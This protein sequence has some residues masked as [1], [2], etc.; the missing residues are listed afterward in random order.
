VLDYS[1]EPGT[2]RPGTPA[3]LRL[4]RRAL[5][6]MDIPYRVFA[7]LLGARAQQV[8]A[9]RHGE[10]RA[11]AAPTT[12]GPPG[13]VLADEY[14]IDVPAGTPAG[15]YLIELG[16]YDP[17]ISERLALPNGET[18]LILGTPLQVS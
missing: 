17:R 6:E 9:Q 12:G 16:F 10:P 13:E 1:L 8:L 14:R 18:R 2:V 11:G 5:S 7:H 3:T 15:A 4:R